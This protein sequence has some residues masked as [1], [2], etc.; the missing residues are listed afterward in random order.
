MN[1]YL[2]IL[3]GEGSFGKFDTWFISHKVDPK[4]QRYFG[5]DG[6]IQLKQLIGEDV[7]F[8]Y[9]PCPRGNVF[10]DG[11]KYDYPSRP[12]CNPPF[13]LTRIFYFHIKDQIQRGLFDEGVLVIPHNRFFG[14]RNGPEPE[15]IRDARESFGI[16]YNIRNCY[17]MRYSFLKPDG[18]RWP[19]TFHI[20]CLH[21]QKQFLN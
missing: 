3:R 7:C 1:Y 6:W 10:L 15:W 8:W 5:K 17:P 12:F 16:V 9:D 11:T 2:V 19:G 4:G 20:L 21:L 13:H 18:E 14:S